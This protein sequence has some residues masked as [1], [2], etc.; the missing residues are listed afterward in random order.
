MKRVQFSTI[1]DSSV[2]NRINKS[3][4][5]NYLRVNGASYRAKISKDLKLSIP[6]VSRA[7]EALLSEDYIRQASRVRTGNGRMTIQFD[8]NSDVG[9]VIGIDL[10][11]ENVKVAITNLGGDIVYSHSGFRFSE[12]IDVSEKV[13]LEIDKAISNYSSENRISKKALNLRG[14][15]IGVPAVTDIHTGVVIDA[16]L[17][18]NLR[19]LDLRTC[20]ESKY[21]V[22]VYVENVVKLSALAEQ[23]TGARKQYRDLVFLE[24]SNGIGAGIILDNHLA[25]GKYGS[26]GEIG[27]SVFKRKDLGYKIGNKGVLEK[28][29]SIESIREKTLQRINRGESS[30]IID[31]VHGQLSRINPRVVCEAAVGGDRLARKVLAE[32]VDYLSLSTI[33]LILILNP[34]IIVLGGEICKLPY[35]EQLFVLPIIDNVQRTIPFPLPEIKLSELGENAGVMGASFLA[36][37]SLLIGEFPYAID[38]EMEHLVAEQRGSPSNPQPLHVH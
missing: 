18:G 29:A 20:L 32:I 4:V 30:T 28:D 23:H 15:G 8:I 17:Y 11:K 27:F 12:D 6:A 16:P 7:I 25:R 21:K 2:Q 14:I 33:Q 19:E 5:Y 13:A 9:T 26:A 10:L 38:T 37:E 35:V 3:I 36:I 22:P 31:A 1:I 24:I 34:Q